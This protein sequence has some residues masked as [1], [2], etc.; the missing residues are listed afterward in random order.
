M[1][2]NNNISWHSVELPNVF[3]ALGSN[4]QGLTTGQASERQAQYGKNVI[5]AARGDS[6]LTLL[7]RQINS[8]LIWTLIVSSVLASVLGRITDGVV[9]IAVVIINTIIGAFQEFK[10]GRAIAA[11]HG[12][13]PNNTVALRDGISTTVAVADLVPGDIVTLAAGDRVP[14]DMRIVELKN[15]KV[16]EALLTGESLTAE[17]NTHPADENSMPGDRKCMLF[18]GTLITS[19]TASCVVVATGMSTELGHISGM[20]SQAANLE[21]PLTIK[22]AGVGKAL[23]VGILIVMLVIMAIGIT[24]A[25]NEGVGMWQALEDSLIF[26]VAL[27]VSAIPEGLPAVVTIAMAIGVQRMAGRHAIIR[28]LPAVETLGSTSV[29]CSDK[30]GTLT[31]NEMTVK[32][33]WTP[34]G[35]CQVE[36]NGYQPEGKFLVNNFFV[37]PLPDYYTNLLEAGVLCSDA[38][39]AWVD[40]QTVI[41]GDPTE[42]AI[43]VAAAKAGITAS[44]LRKA[45]PRLDVVPFDSEYQYMAVLIGDDIIMKGAPEVVIKKCNTAGVSALHDIG[46]VVEQFAQKGIRVL[47]V[48]RKQMVEGRDL[49]NE[50]IAEGFELMGLIGM[51]DPPRTEVADAI[52]VCHQA[53]IEVKMITGDHQATAS[54]IA[55]ELGMTKPEL[56]LTGRQLSEMS[57]D[58]LNA[59][60]LETNIYARVAP[61]HK[62]RLV[63]ALQYHNQVV[64]MTGDGVNDAPAIKQAN[65][66]VAMGITGSSVSKEAADI[67]LADDNFTSICAAVEEG[68]RVYDNLLKSLAFLLPTNIGLALVLVYGIIFF[69][70]DANTLQ[71][72]LPV[73]PKQLLWINLIA[74][75]TLALPLAFEAMEPGIMKRPPRKPE[76]PL[77]SSPLVAQIIVISLLITTGAILLFMYAL[78]NVAVE[79]SLSPLDLAQAQ[80]AVVT[81]IIFFQIFYMLNCRSLYQ[82]FYKVGFFRNKTVFVGIAIILVLQLI[83]I[84]TGFMQNVFETASL[85]I[86]HWA[87][88]FVY[89]LGVFPVMAFLKWINRRSVAKQ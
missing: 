30:T 7:W 42:A 67:V 59:A 5:V 79:G 35:E 40:H 81:F 71:L 85:D 83:F 27:A 20:L 55:R 89:A 78:K 60:V 75:V 62:L 34:R 76:S 22:L 66:G 72:L 12:L 29:I 10:A 47:A 49:D 44:S 28:K 11:L 80:T 58:E 46:R 48:A 70:F 16:D 64:A 24:R 21:T 61:E 82:P 32:M 84:Y 4:D 39:I 23:T 69:P 77:F 38:D 86:T 57:D 54:F 52:A 14:A 74:A 15:L 31:R 19:G 41:A 9:V 13:V 36:G 65:I 73:L 3:E 17:K 43:V 50:M 33:L 51:Y 45:K 1:D 37:D 2:T 6:I 8:P 68:R 63:K 26:A 87:L 88:A 53:G 56:S 18:S 25:L